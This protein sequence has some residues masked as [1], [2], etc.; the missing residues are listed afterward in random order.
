MCG[1]VF[2]LKP[3][4]RDMRAKCAPHQ[5]KP[6]AHPPCDI[7]YE[8]GDKMGL[9]TSN[10]IIARHLPPVTPAEPR[11]AQEDLPRPTKSQQGPQAAKNGHAGTHEMP[12]R[13]TCAAGRRRRRESAFGYSEEYSSQPAECRAGTALSKSYWLK[14]VSA[15]CTKG[16][17]GG[18]VTKIAASASGLNRSC[19]PPALEEH[20]A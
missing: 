7:V 4:A 8:H 17:S 6:H 3:R 1:R 11:H 12:A 18:N 10:L 20:K 5:D 2:K 9:M 19:T 14:S 13:S 16:K 15:D